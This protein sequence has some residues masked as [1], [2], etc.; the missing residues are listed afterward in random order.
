MISTIPIFV[1]GV[2]AVVFGILFYAVATILC[3]FIKTIISEE[4]RNLKELFRALS[5]SALIWF[6]I[7]LFGCLVIILIFAFIEI[8]LVGQN[9]S[10]AA[11]K[12]IQTVDWFLTWIWLVLTIIIWFIVSKYW[13]NSRLRKLQQ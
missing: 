3:S 10:L 11:E 13:R 7:H 1:P 5:L 6:G 2:I 4:N 8:A 9:S 12:K